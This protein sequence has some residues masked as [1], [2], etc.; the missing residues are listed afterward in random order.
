MTVQLLLH[1]VVVVSRMPWCGAS[2]P[3]PPFV[4][5]GALELVAGAVG[6]FSLRLTPDGVCLQ[7]EYR[8][9]L[10]AVGN[11][12]VA[13]SAQVAWMAASCATTRVATC[14]SRRQV[15]LPLSTPA[16]A[17]ARCVAA[18]RK[19][20]TVAHSTKSATRSGVATWPDGQ[21]RCS[22]RRKCAVPSAPSPA[23]YSRRRTRTSP[24]RVTSVRSRQ[25]WT[26]Y[27]RG[28]CACRLASSAS[29][30]ARAR[31]HAYRHAARKHRAS[32]S[33]PA[34][35]VLAPES[36]PR[37]VP[38]TLATAPPGGW[39]ASLA[40]LATR[41]GHSASCSANLDSSGWRHCT[42]LRTLRRATSAS[43]MWCR[44]H[45]HRSRRWWLLSTSPLPHPYYRLT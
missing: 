7:V 8:D 37:P 12:S 39:L 10:L 9:H 45:P 13:V 38:A 32:Q 30:S 40:T 31:W 28:R 1:Q 24:N 14:W 20:R 16:V 2:A 33:Q 3:L 35:P 25:P 18:T 5:A 22:S 41:P 27:V 43:S 26:T 6:G 36:L 15:V 29:N 4:H 44:I 11:G 21:P 23:R 42:S 17:W 34:A 19:G